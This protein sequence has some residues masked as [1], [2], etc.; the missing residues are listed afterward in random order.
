M[1]TGTRAE[2][3][4][5]ESPLRAIRGHPRLEL[6][7]IV[8]GMH[9]LPRFG[10]TIRHIR[11]AGYQVSATVPMQTGKDDAAGEALAVGRGVTGIARALDRLGSEIV[12]VVGDRIEALAAACAAAAGRRVLAHIHGG[13]RAT[14]DVDDAIRNA[15]TRLAHLHLA[16]SE[17]AADRLR[18][19]GEE[20]WRIHMVGAPGLDDIHAFCE[21]DRRDP[22]ATNARLRQLIG[23]LADQPYA[24]IVQHPCGRPA[25]TEAAVMRRLL[26][27][28]KRAR[29]PGVIL[30]PNSDPGHDGILR[31]IREVQ[32]AGDP[33]RPVFPSLARIDYLRLCCR[34]E[35]LVGNS[36]SGII[37]SA[38]MGI[39]AVNIGPR[40]EGRLH[41]GP[42]VIDAPESTIG[43][44]AAIERG[45]RPVTRRKV[46]AGGSVYGSGG[47]GRRI[48]DILAS[49]RMT[50]R[51]LRKALT[52]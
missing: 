43:I 51:L 47:A 29:L 38:A 30:Y 31:V 17:D 26:A 45:S 32:A 13:D 15:V 48:A 33:R 36:S 34:A 50:R 6:Q 1:I 19:M 37:E 7:L 16:A 14:G 42:G 4:V 12:V 3:G 27:A 20:P 41:C 24:V 10:R 21:A 28:V 23:P 35:M 22:A 44:A 9:L 25:A 11:E 46:Q 52:Y 8:T 40:Q 18:L 2:F 5:L 39:P 49:T